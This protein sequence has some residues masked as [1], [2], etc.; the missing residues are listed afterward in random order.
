MT[1]LINIYIYI[2]LCFEDHTYTDNTLSYPIQLM[3]KVSG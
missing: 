3:K 2:F 1:S